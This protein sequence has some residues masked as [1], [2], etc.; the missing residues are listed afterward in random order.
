MNDLEVYNSLYDYLFSDLFGIICP[1]KYLVS[2]K[3][4][5]QITFEFFTATERV[6]VSAVATND[7]I[8]TDL[9]IF[10]AQYMLMFE[11]GE[12]IEVLHVLKD[13]YNKQLN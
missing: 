5:R 13:F 4:P 2:I 1:A 10:E 11:S 6:V 12:G 3:G 7:E 8:L 9:W